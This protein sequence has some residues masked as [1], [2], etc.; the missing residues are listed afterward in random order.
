MTSTLISREFITHL[1]YPLSL[2]LFDWHRW[3]NPQALLSTLPYMISHS[4]PLKWLHKL[5]IYDSTSLTYCFWPDIFAL[6]LTLCLFLHITSEIDFPQLTSQSSDLLELIQSNVGKAEAAEVVRC[7]WD[8]RKEED[9]QG[10]Y[11]KHPLQVE[12]SPHA[13]CYMLHSFA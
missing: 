10:A 8:H 1:P 12:L 13:S 7:N 3:L 2:N 6:T 9:C 4:C 5:D 11:F